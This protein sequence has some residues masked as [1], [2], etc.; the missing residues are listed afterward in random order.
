M[1]SYVW[2]FATPWTVVCQAPLSLEFSRQNYW[3]GLPFPSPRDVPNPGI[4]PE[5][6]VSPALASGFSTTDPPGTLYL[7]C[8]W[9]NILFKLIIVFHLMSLRNVLFNFYLKKASF[10]SEVITEKK[11]KKRSKRKPLLDYWT[12][13]NLMRVCFT[14]KAKDKEEVVTKNK[15]F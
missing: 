14:E 5:P 9:Y 12:P 3:S 10:D 2:L 6:S 13:S 4:K 1:L 15:N 7:F 8:V 11:K